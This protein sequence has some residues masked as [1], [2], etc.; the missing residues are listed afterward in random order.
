MTDAGLLVLQN[1]TDSEKERSLCCEMSPASLQEDAYQ[2]IGVKAEVPSDEEAKEDP[3][4]I[5]FPGIKA[6]P[7]VSCVTVSVLGGF[8]K[9]KYLFLRNFATVN[10]L[11]S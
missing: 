7:Q 11:H 10:S 5:T 9:Y 6:E 3:D 2:A 8:H 4:P 1:V